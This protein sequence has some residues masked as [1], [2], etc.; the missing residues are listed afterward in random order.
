MSFRTYILL[1]PMI[2]NLERRMVMESKKRELNP[3]E[4][5][6]VVGG[7]DIPIMPVI[8]GELTVCPKCGDPIT[9]REVIS[10]S[11]TVTRYMCVN[12]HETTVLF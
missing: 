10:I 8:F 6:E 4:L 2:L 7:D 5:D 11:Q 3:E 1:K 9:S 12:G